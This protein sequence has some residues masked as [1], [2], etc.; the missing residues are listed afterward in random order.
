MAFYGIPYM[1]S[2]DKIA[3]RIIARL[4]EGKRF[5]DLFGG[6]FAMSHAALLSGKYESVYY[7]DLNPLLPP[8]IKD[9]IAGKYNYNRFKPP[10]VRRAE[11]NANKDKDGYIAAIW[12]FGNNN[13]GYLYSQDIEPLKHEAHDFVMF[14]KPTEHFRLIERYVTSSDISKR[15]V[16]FCGAMKKHAKRFDLE[17][18]ERLER[19]QHLEHLERLENRLTINCGSY[20][21]YVYQDGDIVYCDPPYEGTARYTIDFDHDAFYEWLRMR[22]YQVWFSSYSGIADRFTLLWAK[23]HKSTLSAT[24][25]NTVRY[26]CLYTN[27]EQ[28]DD[29]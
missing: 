5:V 4:P 11:F 23:K 20:D 2:K 21:E 24:N 26:E 3:D 18:L 9:A 16:Q 28:G 1:G 27:K 14:G 7:N 6:G 10:F 29:R 8:L 19:L 17:H 13:N 22:P 15:R 25:N 12:S